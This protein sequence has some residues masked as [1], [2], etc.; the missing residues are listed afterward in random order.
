MTGNLVN[1]TLSNA[2]LRIVITVGVAYGSDTR[3]VTQL[4]YEV[5][6]KNPH[7]LSEPEPVVVFSAFG[8]SSLNFELRLFVNDP[9]MYRRLPHELHLAIDDLFRRHQVV[10]AF[11]QCDLHV[12]ELPSPA[13]ALARTTAADLDDTQ[14]AAA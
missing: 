6:A 7:V 3:L 9:V 10:I 13:A 11:P 4:L 8:E 1:W 14:D 5:A 2:D 12:K